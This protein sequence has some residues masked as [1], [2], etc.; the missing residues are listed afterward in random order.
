MEEVKILL[1]QDEMPRRW[2]NIQ[3]DLPEPLPPVINPGTKEPIGPGDLAPLFPMELIKQEVST[4]RYIDIPEEVREA[5][6]QIGR[7][8]PLYRARRLEKALNTPAKIYYKRED[9]SFAGS[10]KPNTAI[11]QAYYNMKEGVE[12]IATETGAGQ[13]GTALS[14]GCA[15]FDITCEVFMVRIS[16]DQKP[17]RRI[18][19]ELYGSKVHPSPSTITN[20]GRAFLEK[21]PNHTGSL[22]LAISEAVEVAATNDDTKYSLG[23]VLNHVLMHQTVVG[24]ETQLQ[25]DKIDTKP[26]VMIGCVGGGSN[27]GGFVYPALGKKLRGEDNSTRFLAVEPKGCPTLTGGEYRYDHGDAARLIPLVKMY[28]LGCDFVPSPIHAGGLRYHG[29]SPSLS[30]LHNTGDVDAVAYDQLETFEAGSLFARTEGLVPAP[31]TSHAIKAAIDE[32]LDAKKKNEERVITFN[33]SGH[34]LLDLK[35][36]ADFIAGRLK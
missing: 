36:Y 27:F 8:S 22:G 32:A 31:E 11:A 14:L 7:P 34:G 28:T 23:S 20:T 9:V 15:L 1:D 19:M 10:H 30:L 33:F 6:F 24:Q 5:Y 3:A 12:K 29:D 35:G 4:D 13:W 26:D 21:D 2:Y 25:F 17:Y 16:Y 18:I